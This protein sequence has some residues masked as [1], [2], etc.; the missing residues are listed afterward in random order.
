M[1]TVAVAVAVVGVGHVGLPLVIEFGKLGRT[2]GVDIAEDKVAHRREVGLP[3]GGARGR[4][5]AR[6]APLTARAWS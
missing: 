4:R 2:I 3:A 1:T 6:L 5:T